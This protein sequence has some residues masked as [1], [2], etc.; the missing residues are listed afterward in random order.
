MVCL[1]VFIDLQLWIYGCVRPCHYKQADRWLQDFLLLFETKCEDAE[2][3]LVSS[4][5]WTSQKADDVEQ[6][7]GTIMNSL[8]DEDV[9]VYKGKVFRSCGMAD[10]THIKANESETLSLC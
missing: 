3:C 9:H 7:S 1:E 4:F 2:V 6:N 10:N 5:T 8:A